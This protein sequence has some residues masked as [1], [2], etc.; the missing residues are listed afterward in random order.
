MTAGLWG[1]MPASARDHEC[2]YHGMCAVDEP[3]WHGSR[4]GAISSNDGGSAPAGR[5]ASRSRAK[6]LQA[7]ELSLALAGV[8]AAIGRGRHGGDVAPTPVMDLVVEET[9]M[10]VSL[11]VDLLVTPSRGALALRIQ[12]RWATG[13]AVQALA[14]LVRPRTR[15]RSE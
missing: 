13:A 1:K 3:P 12:C 14:L 10:A 11:A 8:Q 9:L 7:L 15:R 4:S 5:M 6:G 2:V